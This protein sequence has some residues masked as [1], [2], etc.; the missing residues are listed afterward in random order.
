MQGS[1]GREGVA[2]GRPRT[3]TAEAGPG[4]RRSHAARHGPTRGGLWPALR[5]SS[6][7]GSPDAPGRR[8][9]PRPAKTTL[10]HRKGS[11]RDYL[12]PHIIRLRP[13]EDPS[14]R[15]EA[16]TL[17]IA[18]TPLGR[19]ECLDQDGNTVVRAWFDSLTAELSLRSRFT[20]ETLRRDSSAVDRKSTRLNSSHL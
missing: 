7:C 8:S 15:L 1:Y 17:D 12:E 11:C 18:P 2:L 5:S 10:R 20:L 14:Q 3:A 19:S 4:A 9:I 13:R 16:W 6:G